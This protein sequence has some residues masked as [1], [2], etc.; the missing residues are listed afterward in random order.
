MALCAVI[1]VK[2]NWH[3]TWRA[4]YQANWFMLIIVL[5]G[6]IVNVFTS[7]LK[8]KILLSIHK[9]TIN[10]SQLLKYYFTA[11]FFNNFLPSTIG[12][13][14]YRI[15][16]TFNN[17]VSKAGA[18][19]SVFIERLTGIMA[20]MIIG[21]LAGMIG[22]VKT[23]NDISRLVVIGGLVGIVL[24]IVLSLILKIT[25]N[26]LKRLL[27][28]IVPPKFSGVTEQLKEY[29]HQ[30]QKIVQVILLSF[31]FQLSL[32]FYRLLLVYAVGASISI[33][34]LAVAI[35]LSTFIALAPI[36]INGLGLL[37]GSYIYLLTN[38]HVDYE[39]AF[40]VMILIR[41]LNVSLGLMGGVFYFFDKKTLRA[42]PL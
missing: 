42:D 22:Y 8:W 11:T 7:T 5:I 30:N 41:V 28:K 3:E 16:K 40:I 17:S 33:A 13:D 31:L 2:V 37:D 4:L 27:R 26:P 19:T 39:Q 23:G 6:M 35:A 20:L 21:F 24:L 10:F 1:I 18:I 14:G 15:L 12:G 36:S 9:I 34:N 25:K 38:F 32:L 29:N